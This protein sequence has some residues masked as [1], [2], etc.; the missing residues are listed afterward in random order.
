MK[1]RNLLLDIF[2]IA[3]AFMVV[4]QH[5]AFL[6]DIS[7]EGY[8]LTVQGIFRIAVPIFFII[9]GYYFTSIFNKERLIIWIK[10]IFSL[11]AFWMIF[12]FLFWF[13]PTSFT[14]T[15]VIRT[16]IFGYHHLW[17]LSAMIG[18]GILT[19][20]FKE[21]TTL[22]I[23]LAF[24]LFTI[25]VLIQ[26]LGNYH[27]LSSPI[28]NTL[29]NTTFI[30]RNFLFLGFPFFYIGFIINKKRIMEKTKTNSLILITFLSSCLL[31]SESWFNSVYSLKDNGFD[32]LLFLVLVCPLLFIL[33]LRS[34]LKTENK[35]IA[36]VSTAI[37]LIHPFWLIVLR[38]FTLLEGTSITLLCILL[39]IL[40]SYPIIKAHKKLTFIL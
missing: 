11:Y 40:S 31:L 36:L 17:Y 33:L 32:N 14:K 21:K 20:L 10:H 35:N 26:Y 22:G 12:Y 3:L 23:I 38:E 37:Y 27:L 8:N 7:Q 24:L 28:L 5:G 13:D 2:K 4:A 30:H 15:Y 9:S 1:S 18:A 19:Y 6:N 39:S 25:G 29:A 34:K 16:I